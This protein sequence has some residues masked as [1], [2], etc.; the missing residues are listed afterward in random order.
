MTCCKKWQF[1]LFTALDKPHQLN[2]KASIVLPEYL[3]KRTQKK[4]CLEP[5][6]WGWLHYDKALD[7]AVCFLYHEA[8]TEGKLKV[9][10]KGLSSISK[11]FV[12]WKGLIRI[13]NYTI[14]YTAYFILN[15]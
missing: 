2:Q 5:Q 6:K 13:L 3:V 8:K 9:A 10:N 15:P 1:T 4:G 14:F 7:V 12:N 11:D